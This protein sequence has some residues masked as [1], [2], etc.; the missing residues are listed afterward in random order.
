MECS[1][2]K[3]VCSSWYCTTQQCAFYRGTQ[4][5]V[6][7]KGWLLRLLSFGTLC[8]PCS[9]CSRVSKCLIK[10][11]H[12]SKL[13]DTVLTCSESR[14]LCSGPR[15]IL[16][17][18][19][20]VFSARQGQRHINTYSV[21]CNILCNLQIKVPCKYIV[22]LSVVLVINPE[23]IKCVLDRIRAAQWYIAGYKLSLTA[24]RHFLLTVCAE[25]GRER[26]WRECDLGLIK[27]G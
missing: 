24:A 5:S 1:K 4:P 18:C 17:V 22:V 19:V 13:M 20:S 14:I 9:Q 6:A 10:A 25:T 3:S 12:R 2:Y 21:F 16:F 23:I 8:R 27:R 11:V 7:L 26:S 15:W